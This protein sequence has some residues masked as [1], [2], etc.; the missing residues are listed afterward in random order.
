VSRARCIGLAILATLAAMSSARPAAAA[1]SVASVT[2]RIAVTN[3]GSEVSNGDVAGTGRFTAHGGITD[4]GK[5]VVYRTMNGSHITLRFLAAGVKGRITF[6][7]KIDATL[8]TSRW[9]I[10]SGTR[11]YR[12]LHGRGTERENA[13]YTVSTLTG[14]VWR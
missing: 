12:G 6:V 2:V 8:G 9:T 3:D 14:T 10:A 1:G 7:V 13:T 5:V 11:R 4:R